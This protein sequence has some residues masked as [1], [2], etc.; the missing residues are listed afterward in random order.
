ML[1]LIDFVFMSYLADINR[2]LEYRIQRSTTVTTATNTITFCC[3][4]FS[5]ENMVAIQ[6]L[7]YSLRNNRKAISNMAMLMLLRRLERAD[8]TVHGF[9]STFRDW[10]AERTGFPREIIETAL[11]HVADNAVELA[12]LRSDL[13]E[14]RRALMNLWADHCFPCRKQFGQISANQLKEII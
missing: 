8:I 6:L 2:I 4:A 13:L 11:G 1:A 5:A 10:A 14:K 3:S 7:L 9:R 12:Y